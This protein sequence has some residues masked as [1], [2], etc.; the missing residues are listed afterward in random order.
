GFAELDPQ[1]HVAGVICNNVAG[2]RHYEYL[3]PAIRQ[4]TKAEPLGWLPHHGDWEIPERHL[5]LVTAEEL[6]ATAERWERIGESLAQ[7]VDVERLLAIARAN[8]GREPPV[9]HSGRGN[10]TGGSRPPHA[11]GT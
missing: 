4:H 11:S 8:G 6:A 9:E 3:A 10:A 1:V 2:E 5:G 7:T